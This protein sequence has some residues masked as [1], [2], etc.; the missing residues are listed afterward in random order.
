MITVSPYNP[1]ARYQRRSA[2]RVANTMRLVIL[3]GIFGASGFWIGRLEAIKEISLLT[4]EKH[5]LEL[6]NNE[7]QGEVTKYRAEAQTASARLEQIKAS[8]EEVLPEGPMRTLTLLVK[9]QIESGIDATRLESVIK[10]VSPPQNCAEPQSKRFVVST[11]SY[12]GPK[13]KVSIDNNKIIIVAQGESSKNI[14]G[15]EEAWY[16]PA[17]NIEVTF[18]LADGT[19]EIRKGHLPIIYSAILEDKEY[20]FTIGPDEKSFAKVTYDSCDSR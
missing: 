3:V 18:T 2:R 13:S 5:E 11:P 1:Q 14:K 19:T 6:R 9:E 20:R 15:Q 16:D 4:Q 12:K 17:K 7:L 10:S 8:Y